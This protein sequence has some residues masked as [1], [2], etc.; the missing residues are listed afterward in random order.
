MAFQCDFCM[1]GRKKLSLKSDNSQDF[2]V[3]GEVPASF[4]NNEELNYAFEK[5]DG[6]KWIFYPEDL[7]DPG[8]DPSYPGKIYHESCINRVDRDKVERDALPRMKEA[9][10][11]EFLDDDQFKELLADSR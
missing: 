7:V 10:N 4:K 5:R 3:H 8:M 9:Y 2:Y 1:V 11:E 6:G